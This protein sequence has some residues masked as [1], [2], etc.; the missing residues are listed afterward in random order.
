MED[1]GAHLVHHP[2]SGEGRTARTQCNQPNS[3][4]VDWLVR[5]GG[6]K[7]REE[8]RRKRGEEGRREE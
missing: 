3:L 5:L 7:E 2:G 1:P 8:R 6:G 4:V